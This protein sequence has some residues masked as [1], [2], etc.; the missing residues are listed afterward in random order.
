VISPDLHGKGLASEALRAAMAWADA[1]IAARQSWCMIAP[2]N[3]ASQKIAERIG[4]SR[5]ASAHYKGEEV[6]TY[7]RP[8]E[9]QT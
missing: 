9:G 4:Y 6:L 3:I 7:L 5:V 2:Q 8:R 1:N